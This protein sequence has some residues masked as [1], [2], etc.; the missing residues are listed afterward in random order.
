MGVPKPPVPQR[1]D[2][3]WTMGFGTGLL[4]GTFAGFVFTVLGIF[5]GNIL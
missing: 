1:T 2:D 3:C 4:Y 5:L